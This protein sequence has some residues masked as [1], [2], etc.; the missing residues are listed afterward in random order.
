MSGKIRN[1]EHRCKICGGK[2]NKRM[3]YCKLCAKERH[4]AKVA[5]EIIDAAFIAPRH[6]PIVDAFG[7]GAFMAPKESHD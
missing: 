2:C 1:P 5:K 4:A 3:R 6:S 7:F